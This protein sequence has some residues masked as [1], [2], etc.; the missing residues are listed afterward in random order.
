MHPR[1]LRLIIC[2]HNKT[3]LCIYI[4]IHKSRKVERC[5]KKKEGWTLLKKINIRFSDNK[6]FL[7]LT[8]VMIK[9]RKS[10]GL[11]FYRL[12]VVLGLMFNFFLFFSYCSLM[13]VFLADDV[14]CELSVCFWKLYNTVNNSTIIIT[15][16]SQF[17]YCKICIY[18][19]KINVHVLN[20]FYLIEPLK[21]L[22]ITNLNWLCHYGS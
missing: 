22:R 18:L 12:T 5:T 2:G 17:T 8:H 21:A 7:K 1:K 6:F 3:V 11:S 15:V 13:N 10:R 20:K 14:L 19:W 16:T 4:S 9:G